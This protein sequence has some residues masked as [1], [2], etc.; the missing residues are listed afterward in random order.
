VSIF[1][2]TVLLILFTIITQ[3]VFS[4][5]RFNDSASIN[6]NTMIMTIDT[7]L[8][9][10]SAD[11]SLPTGRVRGDEILTMH[12]RDISYPYLLK[13]QFDST[14]TL[15]EHIG[16]GSFDYLK[17]MQYAKGAIKTPSFISG[18]YDRLQSAYRIS[19]AALSDTI[20][21]HKVSYLLP[22][23][24]IP[25]PT[26]NWTGIVIIANTELPVLG[27]KTSSS[28][29][30]CL[31]P[32]VWDTDGRLI[33][34]KEQSNPRLNG[35]PIVR[36]FPTDAIF[37]SNPSGLSDEISAIV[38][39]QPLKIMAQGLFGE[40]PTDVIINYQDAE[41]ILSGSESIKLLQEA[42][43]VFIIDKAGLVQAL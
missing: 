2:K 36:Y 40:K 9:L 35:S 29:V 30:P 1:N 16:K 26:G 17:A 27:R 41:S 7:A 14:S 13:V 3:P 6:W 12:Y 10:E 28:I 23:P 11:I 18:N 15:N 5:V 8:D 25:L 38:G 4:E 33:Y 43:I 32:K 39:T 37:Q 22:A 21:S 42:K 20:V 31:L 34:S 24:L 19:L